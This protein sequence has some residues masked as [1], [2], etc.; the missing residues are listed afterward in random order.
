M[1]PDSTDWPD[2]TALYGVLSGRHGRNEPELPPCQGEGRGFESRRRL[3]VRGP[4]EGMNGSLRQRSAGSWELRVFIGTDP[5]TGRRVDRSVTVRGSRG[6]AERELVAMVASTRAVRAVGVRSSVSELLEAWFSI[7]STGWAPTTV[8][9]TRS[10]LDRYVHRHLG[11]VA[12]G[13]VTLAMID[14]SVVLR[15]LGRRTHRRGTGGHQDE[16]QS[17]RRPRPGFVLGARR[18]RRHPAPAT[19]DAFVFSDDD[20]AT[21]WKP[22]QVTESFIRHRRGA[23]LRAFRLHDLRHFMATE[24][25]QAGVPIVIRLKATRSP[26]RIHHTRQIRPRRPRRR[27]QRLRHPLANPPNPNLT[28]TRSRP[29]RSDQE[30]KGPADAPTRQRSRVRR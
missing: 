13:D 26:P 16:T 7:A 18:P 21:A 2:A 28:P 15:R 23:G 4:F 30:S 3:Q 12:V 24:M 25:L 6:E 14:T 19:M 10:V 1:W 20:G 8:R 29:H 11:H 5:V 22:N 17:C 9:Q 27:R